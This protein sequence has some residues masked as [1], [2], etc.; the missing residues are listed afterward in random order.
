MYSL[1]HP[2]T[3]SNPPMHSLTHATNHALTHSLTHS[4]NQPTM[5]SLNH[6]YLYIHIIYSLTHPLTQIILFSFLNSSACSTSPHHLMARVAV[7]AAVEV[8]GVGGAVG[9][10]RV[11]V[12]RARVLA[13]SVVQTRPSHARTEA[14]VRRPRAT[15]LVRHSLPSS[16]PNAPATPRGWSASRSGTRRWCW[17]W[18]GPRQCLL[19]GRRAAGDLPAQ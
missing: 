18:G 4:T 16:R 1:R 6:P 7:D 15:H 5:H 8:L 10:E 19:P 11:P 17:R 13:H 9:E 3:H 14:L 2:C 12:L